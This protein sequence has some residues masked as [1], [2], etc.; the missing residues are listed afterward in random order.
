[1]FITESKGEFLPI[2]FARFRIFQVA[3]LSRKCLRIFK[4]Y[5]VFTQL[6]EVFLEEVKSVHV[7]LRFT[8]WLLIEHLLLL[9]V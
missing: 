3:Q 7:I 2:V 4:G 6:Y 1:M 5:L 8:I 9:T